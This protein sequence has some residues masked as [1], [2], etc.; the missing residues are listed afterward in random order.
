M[1]SFRLSADYL[2]DAVVNQLSRKAHKVLR[3]LSQIFNQR[4]EV[5]AL[6][7]AHITPSLDYISRRVQ[8]SRYQTSRAITEL[9]TAGLI[10]RRQ[11]RTASGEWKVNTFTLGK[12]FKALWQAFK[13]KKIL[14]KIA[15]LHN[16]AN[17]LNKE[18]L[19]DNYFTDFMK[20]WRKTGGHGMATAPLPG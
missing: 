14:N 11:Q 18:P 19:E 3:V 13:D 17:I 16:S 1:S 5:I 10:R 12:H 6:E 9:E 8:I 4:K 2:P 7:Y 20:L 15:G